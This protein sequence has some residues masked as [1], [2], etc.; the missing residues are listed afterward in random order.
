M[1]N[2]TLRYGS[3]IKAFRYQTKTCLGSS[4]AKS[5]YRRK[6]EVGFKIPEGSPSKSAALVAK[7][8]LFKCSRLGEI[9]MANPRDLTLCFESGMENG[10][11][12]ID[13]TLSSA[14]LFTPVSG[15]QCDV[16]RMEWEGLY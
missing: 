10:C 15:K 6:N 7:S 1:N 5:T 12:V 9:V 16:V 14:L 3:N 2:F 4:L 11:P 8:N 13:Y